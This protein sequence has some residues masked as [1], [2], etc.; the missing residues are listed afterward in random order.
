MMLVDLG[1]KKVD[2][3][4]SE[5]PEKPATPIFEREMRKRETNKA[6]K[7]QTVMVPATKNLVE[8]QR[9]VSAEQ[10]VKNQH[11]HINLAQEYRHASR[12]AT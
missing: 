4:P 8:G 10:E 1:C 3:E 11:Q 9:R 5:D 6:D 2:E 12:Q 7:L